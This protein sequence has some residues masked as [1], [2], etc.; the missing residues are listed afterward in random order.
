MLAGSTALVACNAIVGFG[1]FE[2]VTGATERD[3]DDAGSRDSNRDATAREDGMTR[4]DAPS[5]ACDPTRPFGPPK[6]LDGPVN[7]SGLEDAPSLTA[8]E[9]TM[10]FERTVDLTNRT[11]VVATRASRT[12]AFSAPTPVTELQQGLN[13]AAVVTPTITDDGLA[14]FYAGEIGDEADIYSA[15]RAV[16]TAPFSNARKL[17]RVNSNRVEVYPSVMHDGA[18]LWFTSERLGGITRHL[19]RSVRDNIGAY[20]D[21]TLVTELQSSN[22]EAGVALS[23][24]G[25]TIYFGTDRP[26]GLGGSDIWIAKRPSLQAAFG[27]PTPVTELSSTAEDRPAWLSRDGCRM[28]FTSDRAGTMDIFMAA[29]P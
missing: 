3:D 7:S 2:R 6:A 29:R 4:E 1:D 15:S 26:G 27:T 20:Q 13:V 24:D 21:P 5:A 25:L 23:A 12:A 10:V 19:F 17:G 9:L 8:D 18:E 22:N 28:Y 14:I 11:I 16:I